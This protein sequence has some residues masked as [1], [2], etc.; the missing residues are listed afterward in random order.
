MAEQQVKFGAGLRYRLGEEL[1]QQGRRRALVLSTPHQSQTAADI[2]DKL[3]EKLAGIFSGAV[4]HTPTD[5]TRQALD[6]AKS[7]NADCVIAVGGGST[8]GLG[9]ALA[10][11]AGL[12]QLALPTTY[13]GSEATPILGQ[14]ENGVKTTQSGEKILPETVVY[15]PELAVSL[16]VDISVASALNAVAHA[17]EALYAKDKTEQ[18]TDYALRGMRAFAEH[19]P[20]VLENPNDVRAREET[21]RGAWYCGHVLG[22]V[23]MALHHKLCHSLGGSF[24]L[25]HAETHAAVLPHAIAYNEKAAPELLRPIVEI[26]NG[27]EADGAGGTLWRFA[28]KINAPQALKNLGLAEADLPK[29]ADIAVKNPYWNPREID[30]DEILKLLCRAWEG[31]A[32]L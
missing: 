9:K 12:P 1:E 25:P 15:D 32:P 3:G 21:L 13:A 14:T 20:A 18:T 22:K 10:L 5:I 7:V 23:G 8:I 26:F 2:A 4:M 30:R 28:K 17:A 19:L 29:A 11:N 31:G 16:P 27:G 6:Y 24:N